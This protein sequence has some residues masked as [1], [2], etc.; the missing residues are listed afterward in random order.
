MSSDE[1]PHED[2]GE[3]SSPSPDSQAHQDA[4]DAFVDRLEGADVPGLQRVVLFGSVARGTHSPES[5]VDVLAVLDDATDA[6]AVEER[7]RDLAYDVMLEHGT[8]FSVHA[9]TETTMERRS[10]HPFFQNVLPDGRA[11]YG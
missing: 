6:P 8:V 2:A 1:P 10:N 5:D 3:Q 4:V 7:L 11:I 9:V